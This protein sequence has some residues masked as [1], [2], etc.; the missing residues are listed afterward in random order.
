[1]I[2]QHSSWRTTL[3]GARGGTVAITAVAVG[4]L[5]MISA[6][7]CSGIDRAAASP[8]AKATPTSAPPSASPAPSRPGKTPTSGVPS[9]SA[10][11]GAK[12]TSSSPVAPSPTAAHTKPTRG[13]IHQVV[14]A[15]TMH[16]AKPVGLGKKRAPFG[17]GV[18]AQVTGIH[19]QYVK[20]ELPG[21]LSGESVVFNLA[22][23][24]GSQKALGLN[25]TTVTVTDAK[26]DP[27]SEI[28]ATGPA[29][30]LPNLVQAGG[31]AT[32]TYVFIVPKA[33]RNPIDIDVTINADLN[34]VVF[35]GN[36][37]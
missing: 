11:P 7:G 8:T 4:G 2:N 22:I 32:A 33:D 24:N 25:A 27:A 37:G 34:V 14:P 1:M 16:T 35:H 19:Q 6:T 17:S 29:A 36:A 12:T 20:A 10:T 28:T 15:H 3:A 21:Q 5:F 23:K 31:T 9:S 26:G 30:P 18:T 13:S